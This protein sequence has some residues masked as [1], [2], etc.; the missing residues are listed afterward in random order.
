MRSVGARK[1]PTLSDRASRVVF[2]VLMLM[3]WSGGVDLARARAARAASQPPAASDPRKTIADIMEQLAGQAEKIRRNL[4]RDSFDP[5]ALADKLGKD[6]A[7]LFAWVRDQTYWV[8]YRGVLRSDRG[9]LME[10][11]GNS[12]DRSILLYSLLKSA[13]HSAR[14]AHAQLNANQATKLLAKLRRPG[15]SQSAATQGAPLLDKSLL[16][17]LEKLQFPVRRMEEDL[18]QRVAEQT[19]V[20]LRAIESE[21]PVHHAETDKADAVAALC[22]HWWVQVQQGSGW[23]DL[24]PLLPDSQPGQSLGPP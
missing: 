18:V 10:R 9:V 21:N 7:G 4:P 22:D 17:R 19:P 1:M 15:K 20:L 23:Q 16:A 2:C 8:P 12:V 11:I 3:A 24:D 13:G 14:L 6:P 5:G